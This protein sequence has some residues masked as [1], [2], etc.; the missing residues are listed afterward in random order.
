M[1]KKLLFRR[2]FIISG[3]A[4]LFYLY[5]NLHSI[6]VKRYTIEIAKLPTEFQGFTILH[7]TDLHCK[8]YG[9]GQ[10]HLIKLIN[11]Q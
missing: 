10:S 8:E 9:D 2:A 4:A 7:L 1:G 3:I 11:R 5:F 6:A